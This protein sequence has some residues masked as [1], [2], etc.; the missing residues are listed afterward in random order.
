MY[1]MLFSLTEVLGRQ[2]VMDNEG[3]PRRKEMMDFG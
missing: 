1:S 2:A 3:K